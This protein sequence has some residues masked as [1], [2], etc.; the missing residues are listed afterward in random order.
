MQFGE[1]LSQLLKKD[2][3]LLKKGPKMSEKCSW[4]E[5]GA[6]E[7]AAQEELRNLLNPTSTEGREYEVY[8]LEIYQD[9]I[10][11]IGFKE[12]DVYGWDGDKPLPYRV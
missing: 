5:L 3:E 7:G 11:Y 1:F 12:D 10:C 2:P 6:I 8:L 9:T 4:L